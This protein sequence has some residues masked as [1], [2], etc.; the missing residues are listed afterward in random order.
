MVWLS[1]GGFSFFFVGLH[2]SV[3]LT[4]C[5]MPSRLGFF[6][7]L[8]SGCPAF[9]PGLTLAGHARPGSRN[10]WANFREAPVRTSTTRQ[11]A[12][13]HAR[14]SERCVEQ[15][16]CAAT[17]LGHGR[18]E[19]AGDF[20][21]LR[22]GNLCPSAFSHRL[23]QHRRRRRRPVA[24]FFVLGPGVCGGLARRGALALGLHMQLA[25]LV[26]SGRHFVRS[27][28]SRQLKAC[29]AE[30]IPLGLHPPPRASPIASMARHLGPPGSIGTPSID[31]HDPLS[32]RRL[33]SG[34]RRSQKFSCAPSATLTRCRGPC[35][36]DRGRRWIPSICSCCPS[37]PFERLP[38]NGWSS[39]ANDLLAASGSGSHARHAACIRN[40]VACS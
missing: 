3:R 21:P 39:A 15:T 4:D 8:C 10:R 6:F 30:Y 19:M 2:Q 20:R 26:V 37:S 33:E 32:T 35:Q 5:L 18:I 28:P 40:T 12:P 9:C 13:I 38:R 23:E 7:L 1:G 14:L 29:R 31:K 34:P 17:L 11:F 16:F 27:R 25:C 22:L 36:S 24:S